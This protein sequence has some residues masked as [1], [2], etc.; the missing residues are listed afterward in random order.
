MAS[1]KKEHGEHESLMKMLKKHFNK[2]EDEME[3]EMKPMKRKKRG[4]YK[5]ATSVDS[6]FMYDDDV[7]EDE[8]EGFEQNEYDQSDENEDVD[9]ADGYD[10]DGEYGDYDEDEDSGEEEDGLMPRSRSGKNHRKNL[11][12]A[13]ISKKMSKANRKNM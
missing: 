7:N 11:A 1:V 8:G 4:T 2:D 3:G 9:E 10:N 12:I 5:D 6:P 13:V